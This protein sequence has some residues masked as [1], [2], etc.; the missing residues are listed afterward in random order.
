MCDEYDGCSYCDRDDIDDYNDTC[1]RKPK[2]Q[3]RTK[4]VEVVFTPDEYAWAKNAA[5]HAGLPLATYIR[6]CVINRALIF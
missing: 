3:R 4:R 5:E 2:Q 1:N 6:S